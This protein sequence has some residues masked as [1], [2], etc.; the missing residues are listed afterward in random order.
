M[1]ATPRGGRYDLCYSNGVF[2]QIAPPERLRAAGLVRDALAPRALRF[3]LYGEHVTRHGSRAALASLL[4][5]VAFSLAVSAFLLV[6]LDL[7]ERERAGLSHLL[8][9][10]RVRPARAV[11]R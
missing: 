11:A 8:A 6:M 3:R 7:I 9:P 2:H 10:D 4:L 1:A 5:P